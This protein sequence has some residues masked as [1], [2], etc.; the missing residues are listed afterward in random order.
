[1]IYKSLQFRREMNR[2]TCHDTYWQSQTAARHDVCK[3]W[4]GMGRPHE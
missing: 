3:L 1:M 4:H 2:Y